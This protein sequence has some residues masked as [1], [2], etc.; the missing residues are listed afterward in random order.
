MVILE[1]WQ[2]KIPV[3]ATNLGDI[4]LM[5]RREEKWAGELL[6]LT[7][8][9]KIDVARLA[10]QMERFVAD[11]GRHAELKGNVEFVAEKF[12]FRSMCRKYL[13]VYR[14]AWNDRG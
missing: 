9:G 13:D 12:D 4:P 6:E 8:D 10:G 11:G 1:A 7:E 3:L 2:A 5:L 14:E